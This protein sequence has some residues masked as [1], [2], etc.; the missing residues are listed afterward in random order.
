MLLGG[1]GSAACD[2]SECFVLGCLEFFD[3]GSTGEGM[4]NGRG[5]V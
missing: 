5:I 2:D 3:V 4:P 1:G